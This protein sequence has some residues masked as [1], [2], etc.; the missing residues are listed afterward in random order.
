MKKRSHLFVTK[1]I[2]DQV[3]KS[4]RKWLLFGSILPDILVYTYIKKHTWMSSYDV[5]IKR[6]KKL[7]EKGTDSFLSYLK[8]GYVLH[9]VEDFFTYAHNCVFEG[10][11]SE[12]VA[13]ENAFQNHLFDAG[14]PADWDADEQK[15]EV[16]CSTEEAIRYLNRKHAQYLKEAGTIQT[17]AR[18]IRE[19]A[20]TIGMFLV[21]AF[22]IN[23]ME[24]TEEVY[25]PSYVLLKSTRR[26]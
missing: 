2:A 6:I 4:K 22:A 5:T 15:K 18:Y 24:E 16:I 25:M 21:R 23:S 9:Y 11:F 26:I 8:L 14:H 10:D 19:A 17:D 20:G 3:P 13:Y 12:H 1:E 7:E